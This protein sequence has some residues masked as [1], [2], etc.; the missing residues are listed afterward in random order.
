MTYT[1]DQKAFEQELVALSIKHG[2]VLRG[3]GCCG[4]PWIGPIEEACDNGESIPTLRELG[5]GESPKKTETFSW[6]PKEPS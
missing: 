1:R 4:S 3:C 5:L 6:D 2:F